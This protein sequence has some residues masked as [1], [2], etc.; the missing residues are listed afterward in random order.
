MLDSVSKAIYYTIAASLRMPV[1]Q[2]VSEFEKFEKL[3]KDELHFM[4]WK[5]IKRIIKSAVT[6][7]PYYKNMFSLIGADPDDIENE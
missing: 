4:Q 3:S 5:K 1:F 6:N 2:M 7:S